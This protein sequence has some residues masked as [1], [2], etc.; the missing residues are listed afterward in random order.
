M[1]SHLAIKGSACEEVVAFPNSF[2]SASER[3]GESSGEI[4]PCFARPDSNNALRLSDV[5]GA[6]AA[7]NTSLE[8]TSFPP[9]CNAPGSS[10]ETKSPSSADFGDCNDSAI[11]S[12]A[13]S[14]AAAISADFVQSSFA[15]R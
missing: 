5:A 15:A 9:F 7:F 14:D 12:K 4:S 13:C 6:A 11:T 1:R 2:T 8:A 3:A 10:V